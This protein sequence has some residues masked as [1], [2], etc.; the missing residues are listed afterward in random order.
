MTEG[1]EVTY[2]SGNFG[3]GEVIDNCKAIKAIISELVTQ[4]KLEHKT[5]GTFKWIDDN[6]DYE[7]QVVQYESFGEAAFRLTLK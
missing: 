6:R 3:I 4:A 1:L 2:V 7:V 5:R